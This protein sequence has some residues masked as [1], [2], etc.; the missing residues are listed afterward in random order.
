MC[1]RAPHNRCLSPVGC[2]VVWCGVVLPQQLQ[3]LTDRLT[4]RFRE[5]QVEEAK[6]FDAASDELLREIIQRK[7]TYIKQLEEETRTDMEDSMHEVSVAVRTAERHAR[8][9]VRV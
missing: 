5:H 3:L 9:R 6:M 1:V 2:D 8:A 4:A 7:T